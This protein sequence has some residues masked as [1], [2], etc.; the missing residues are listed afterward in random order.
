MWQGDRAPE[1]GWHFHDEAQVTV[2][3]AGARQFLIGSASVLVGP[4]EALVIP[5]GLPHRNMLLVHSGTRCVN[6]YAPGIASGADATIITVK[7]KALNA[8]DLAAWLTTAARPADERPVP[9]TGLEEVVGASLGGLGRVAARAGMSR[10]TLTRRFRRA[11]GLPPHA[12]RVACRLNEARRRLRLGEPIAGI[13]ADLGFAD[14]SHFGRWFKRAFG[15]TPR[16]YQAGHA[17]QI[18]QTWEVV[19]G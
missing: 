2:V 18:F 3:L 5:A 16:S 11:T 13:A 7:D 4:G 14:Q 8:E 17:P 6:F 19:P 9:R 12:Y 15:A 10:E 1:T